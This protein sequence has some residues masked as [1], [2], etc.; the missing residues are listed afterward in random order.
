MQEA[1]RVD[2]SAILAPGS[3]RKSRIVAEA[4]VAKGL[5]D[6]FLDEESESDESYLEKV[7]QEAAMLK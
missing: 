3:K 6:D 2:K 4:E 1:D 7:S 5:W